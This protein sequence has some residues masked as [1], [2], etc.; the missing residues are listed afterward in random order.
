MVQVSRTWGSFAMTWLPFLLA[1]ASCQLTARGS[2][3]TDHKPSS[4][5]AGRIDP[6]IRSHKGKVAIA[7]KNLRTGESFRYRAD[8]VMPTASLIKF[9]VMI[10][11]YRQA[12]AQVRLTSIHV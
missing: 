10:E 6:L 7:V 4:S 8:E 12:A 2:D 9:P 5:L 3:P 11:V 1:M